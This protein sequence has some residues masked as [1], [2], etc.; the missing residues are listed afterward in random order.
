[1]RELW[2]SEEGIETSLEAGIG[3]SRRVIEVAEHLSQRRL[4]S[5]R[6][7]RWG[8]SGEISHKSIAAQ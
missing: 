4:L 1:V 5:R 8:K 2:P 7:P 3:L 6:K